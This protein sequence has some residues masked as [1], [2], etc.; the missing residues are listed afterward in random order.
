MIS[1]ELR[2]AINEQIKVELFS[3]YMYFAMSAYCADENLSG[4]SS[5]MRLQAQE[6]LGHALRFYDFLLERGGRIELQ[7]IEQPPSEFGTPLEVMEKSLE[8]ERFVTARVD[9]L[10]DLAVEEGDRSAQVMLQWFITEQVEEESSIGDIVERMKR[11]GADGPAL[12]MI[13]TQLGARTSAE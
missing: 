6:E 8:H 7:A 11:F 1:D 9:S 4:F 10:Y 13:D 2:K 3:A 5:W 12:L